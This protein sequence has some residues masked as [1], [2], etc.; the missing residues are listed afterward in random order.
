[1]AMW[2]AFLS[3]YNG[4]TM[5]LEEQYLSSNSMKL[6]TDA[7][8]SKGFSGIYKSRWFFGSFPEQWRNLNI[9][10]LEFYPIVLAVC[11]WGDLW[12]NHSILF[13][14]DNE[15]LVSVINKQSSKDNRVMQMVRYLVLTCLKHNIN[16]RAK[17]IPGKNNVLADSLSRLQVQEFLHL[18]PDARR[19]PSA[20]PEE[21]M[22]N[23]FWTT[24]Q[25]W[26][27]LH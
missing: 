10:T 20:I 14:T 12:A 1:M 15:A 19:E 4:K 24:L 7:A 5:F 21:L 26:P 18:A 13:F 9:M 8:K 11:I 16:F 22:P 17:H 25:N 6:F 2:L 27:Q 3:S 23:N